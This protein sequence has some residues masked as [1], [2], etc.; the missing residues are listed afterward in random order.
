MQG[1]FKRSAIPG[2]A[3]FLS[4]ALPGAALAQDKWGTHLDVEAKPGTERS[5]GEADL[6]LP[7]WQDGRAL[8]FGNARLRYASHD[9]EERNL[10][11][12]YR[13]MLG[14]GW[15]LGGYG[16]LDR[17][18]ST[19][20]NTFNQVMLGAEALGRDWDFRGNLYRPRGDKAR[21]LG[22]ASTASLSGAAIQVSTA[23][24]QE[25]ALKGYDL[26]AGWRV[27]V[28]E[29]E[30]DRQLRVYA[31]GYRFADFGTRVAGPRL[32]AELTLH[33]F[34]VTW[35]GSQLVL[36][37]EV[38]DDDARGSQGFVSVRLRIPLGGGKDAGR[39]LNLQE[40][41]M[42]A[43]VVRDVDVV[44][45]TVA[46]APVVENATATAN[47]QPIAI[48]DSGTTSG[49]ALQ[50][51]L[52]AAGPNSTVVLTGTY[53]TTGSTTLQAGQTL[54]GAGTVQVSTPSGY[55]ATL[56]TPGATI[57]ADIP[58][59]GTSAT[60]VMASS[61]TLAG[62]TL[63]H[64]NTSGD[65]ATAVRA[66]GVSNVQITGNTISTSAGGTPAPL[67]S[68]GI[69]VLA[70]S[71]NVVVSNNVISATGTNMQ[72][73]IGVNASPGSFGTVTISGNTISVSGTGSAANAIKY[74]IGTA[75]GVPGGTIAT[76]TGNT[77][78]V[79]GPATTSTFSVSVINTAVAAGSTGNAATGAGCRFLVGTSGTIGFADGTFCP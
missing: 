2:V 71:T 76:I 53:T 4:C 17:R 19:S 54:M 3:V 28:W 39:T 18:R 27:P 44:T 73:I 68:Q 25:F 20:G 13:R 77:I 7:L 41:R 16:Y 8:L 62:M 74:G 34:P 47:G 57:N 33:E 64:F 26:E 38:Q 1:V 42:A 5:L 37:A 23:T 24:L 15:N 78:S 36:G 69:L 58:G 9:S 60:V 52:N 63:T 72:N 56:R 6:F 10:G 50:G 46:S 14:G 11:L 66:A 65:S 61:S 22:T 35:K 48:L 40:R 43:P 70:G 51:A 32:R 31:G 12:G 75:G 30:A 59:S 79:T 45:H 49:A 67:A 29:A 21:D 55:T